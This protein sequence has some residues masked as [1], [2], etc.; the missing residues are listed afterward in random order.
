MAGGTLEL[1]N[2]F[3]RRLRR[4]RPVRSGEPGSPIIA[5]NA[6]DQHSGSANLQGTEVVCIFIEESKDRADYLRSLVSQRVSSDIVK[7][8]VRDGTFSDH[9]TEM[10]DYIDEQNL[11]L[12]AFVMVDP[13]GVKGNSMALIERILATKRASVLSRSCTNPSVVFTRNRNLNLT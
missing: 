3:H 8:S 12:H 13:F 7:T 9:M 1:T 6:I 10:L 2:R 4:T 5:L 11:R